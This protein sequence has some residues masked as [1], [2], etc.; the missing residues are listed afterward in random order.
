MVTPFDIILEASRKWRYRQGQQIWKNALE[1]YGVNWE[2]YLAEE[3]NPHSRRTRAEFLS[4]KDYYWSLHQQ[5][6]YWLSEEWEEE[7]EERLFWD[8]ET[9]DFQPRNSASP[10]LAT[11]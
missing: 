2:M 3:Y 11:T 10:A 6:Q 9:M 4:F 7:A 5:R 8:P 1:S